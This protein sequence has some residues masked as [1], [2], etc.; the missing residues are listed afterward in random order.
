M[1]RYEYPFTIIHRCGHPGSY[2]ASRDLLLGYKE[3]LRAKDCDECRNMKGGREIVAIDGKEC[4]LPA[5]V[6][7]TAA[8]IEWAVK[9]RK[10]VLSTLLKTRKEGEPNPVD[11]MQD[12]TNAK[13]WIDNRNVTP[14][15]LAPPLP[16]KV[17]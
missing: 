15:Q 6:T 10:K 16:C 13:W 7:G 2:K 14:R 8:Q 11:W 5:I 4:T 12:H 9:I 1:S 17:A 3:R